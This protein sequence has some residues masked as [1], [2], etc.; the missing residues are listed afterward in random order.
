MATVILNHRVKNYS[1]WKGLY[2][3]DAERRNNLGLTE[4]T[5]GVKSD[6][7]EHVYVIWKTD[8]FS[9]IE[10]ML[11]DPDLKNKMQEAGVIDPP[12]VVIIR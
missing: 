3:K 1:T 11:S 4:K 8:N 12:E 6:D 10:N 2:E 9:V 7:S 5:V